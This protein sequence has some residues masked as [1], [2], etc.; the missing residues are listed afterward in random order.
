MGIASSTSAVSS[1]PI[2]F[3]N[4][5]TLLDIITRRLLQVLFGFV[6]REGKKGWSVI[7]FESIMEQR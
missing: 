4:I 3:A 7:S 1:G 6:R 5:I 2:V